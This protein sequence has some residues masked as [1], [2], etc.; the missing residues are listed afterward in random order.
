MKEITVG[1]IARD[2]EPHLQITLKCECGNEAFL[3]EGKEGEG[4]KTAFVARI[5]I[6]AQD[7]FRIK[8]ECGSLYIV[9]PKFGC[10][11]ITKIQDLYDVVHWHGDIFGDYLEAWYGIREALDRQTTESIDDRALL[12]MI[13]TKGRINT[14]SEFF[15]NS[16]NPEIS[17]LAM[18]YHPD[19]VARLDRLVQMAHA[20]KG[21][22]G[23]K[24]IYNEVWQ[25][26]C[27]KGLALPF[28]DEEFDPSDL[29]VRSVIA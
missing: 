28:P 27:G 9:W 24:K 29:L 7:P 8:C 13:A 12:S 10:V 23:L 2:G 16:R 14:V 17:R 6:S 21:V 20:C 25:L 26:T 5:G 19:K 22:S 15:S 4:V 1:Y 18:R 11:T 3:V